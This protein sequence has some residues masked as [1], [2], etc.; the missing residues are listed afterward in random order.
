MKRYF[1]WTTA[2][3]GARDGIAEIAPNC[4]RSVVSVRARWLR[5]AVDLAENEKFDCNLAFSHYSLNAVEAFFSKELKQNRKAE[6][7]EALELS[8]EWTRWGAPGALCGGEVNS[9]WQA[10]R[11]TATLHF[12]SA[13]AFNH[14]RDWDCIAKLL[15]SNTIGL[16]HDLDMGS[17]ET[18]LMCKNSHNNFTCA[19]V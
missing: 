1:V 10:M 8:G 19:R 2:L 9:Y 13:F 6:R 18:S 16:P 12:E 3:T 4:S 7:R 15:M 17:T 11:T 14:V 5:A